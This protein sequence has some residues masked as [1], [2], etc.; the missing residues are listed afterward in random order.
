MTRRTDSTIETSPA[1]ATPT[2]RDARLADALRLNLQRRKAQVRARRAGVEPEDA[3]AD[4]DSQTLEAEAPHGG[5][6]T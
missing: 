2:G 4:R 1:V 3:A 5:S 6:E